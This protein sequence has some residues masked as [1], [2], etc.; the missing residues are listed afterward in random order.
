M[1]LPGPF[2]PNKWSQK[3][4]Y[5]KKVFSGPHFESRF[6]ETLPRANLP[7]GV[8]RRKVT[9]HRSERRNALQVAATVSHNMDGL[10]SGINEDV[11]P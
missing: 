3:G 9:D 1:G 2:H 8:A 5:L 10:P 6:P 7:P 11:A 4:P